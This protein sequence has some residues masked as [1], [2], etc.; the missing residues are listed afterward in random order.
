M[1]VAVVRCVLQDLNNG[2]MQQAF[3]SDFDFL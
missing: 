2:E 1:K 3:S